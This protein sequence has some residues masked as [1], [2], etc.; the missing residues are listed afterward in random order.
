MK[1]YTKDNTEVQI[2]RELE[3]GFLVKKV[4]YE[5][6][7]M[8]EEGG[9][10]EVLSDETL[11]FKKGEL[12]SRPF[13]E[14]LA[15]EV[16]GLSQTMH[17]LQKEIH[18]LVNTKRAMETAQGKIKDWPFLQNAL[19]Y[20][21]GDFDYILYMDTLEVCR[22]QSIYNSPYICIV[23]SKE[24]GWQLFKMR[25]ENYHSSSDDKKIHVFRTIEEVTA[26]SKTYLLQKISKWSESYWNSDDNFKSWFNGLHYSCKAK[27]DAEVKEAFNAKYA[28]LRKKE[29]K[30]RQEQ[31]AKEIQEL[32]NK[33]KKLE[34]LNTQS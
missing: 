7:D 32:E 16:E 29:S 34:S 1:K 17:N 15:S 19:D 6:Y 8:E 14:K 11:F 5:E 21:N 20:L 24:K 23:N 27:E 13:T 30:K 31:L 12:F 4:L 33:K 9:S 25:S 22:K 18:Q 10:G 2:I 26:F 28:E 3:D